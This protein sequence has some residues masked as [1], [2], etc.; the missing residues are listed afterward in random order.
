[1]EVGIV[2][3]CG[4]HPLFSCLLSLPWRVTIMGAGNFL[5]MKLARCLV[6]IASSD[7]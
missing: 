6:L 4:F 5:A 2:L 1:M 7:R 3:M